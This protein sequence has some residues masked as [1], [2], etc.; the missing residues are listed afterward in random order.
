LVFHDGVVELGVTAGFE[1]LDFSLL[2]VELEDGGLDA[3]LLAAETERLH[4]EQIVGRLG[5][6]DLGALAGAL[7]SSLGDLEPLAAQHLGT[8]LPGGNWNRLV[9]MHIVGH[10]SGQ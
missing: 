9:V 4:G 6:F 1:D 7:G 5:E 3:R 2:R 8:D 10:G